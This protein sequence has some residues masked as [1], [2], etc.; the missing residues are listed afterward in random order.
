[1]SEP[2]R[3]RWLYVPDLGSSTGWASHDTTHGE[4]EGPT[5]DA[6]GFRIV[7]PIVDDDELE[8]RFLIE[9]DIAATQSREYLPE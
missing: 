3:H 1:M 5:A 2:A 8:G 4:D 9:G 7:A 6:I